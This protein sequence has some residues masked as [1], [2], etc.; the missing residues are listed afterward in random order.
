MSGY[1]QIN[2][3]NIEEMF[4][5]AQ[6]NSLTLKTND[7]KIQQARLGKIS[8]ILSIPDIAGG[9]NGSFTHNTKLP[10]SILPA[11]AFGGQSGENLEIATGTKY[12]TGF[13]QNIDIKLV[14]LEGLQNLKLAHINFQISQSDAELNKRSLLENIAKTYFNIIQLQEQSLS[15]QSNI[16][17]ADTLLQISQKKYHAGIVR[18]QDVNDAKVNL[19]SIQESKKQ[20]DFLIIQQYYALKI[21]CDIPESSE[22]QISEKLDK[23]ISLDHVPTKTDKLSV[24]NYLLKEKYAHANW[25]KTKLSFLPTLS[26]VGS[27]NYNTY[28]QEYTLLGGNWINSNFLGLRLNWTIPNSSQIANTYNAKFNYLQAQ[29]ATEQAKIKAS[30]EQSQLMVNIAKTQSQLHN[31]EEIAEL[32]NE[33]YLKNE[34]LYKSGILGLDR[35][36]SSFNNRVNAQ[37]NVIKGKVE[38]AQAITNIRLKSKF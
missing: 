8:A 32:E 27:N 7:I 24:H 28:N 30:N 16:N 31:F 34:N 13:T 14:N 6:E 1:S 9:V 4:I 5:Y 12:Q 19:I 20:I 18:Q 36:I 38:L 22:I 2:V 10:V 25:K 11:S 15:A 3:S 37:Y 17:A 29:K 26:F 23:A 35:L 33:T 21:L